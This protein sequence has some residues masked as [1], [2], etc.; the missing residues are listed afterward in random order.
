MARGPPVVSA[1][2]NPRMSTATDDLRAAGAPAGAESSVAR[3][4]GGG[5]YAEPA[6]RSGPSA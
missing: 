5:P 2:W 4:P 6:H 1:D 3:V